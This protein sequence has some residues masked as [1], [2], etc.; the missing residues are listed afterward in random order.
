MIFFYFLIFFI[1]SKVLLHS[2]DDDYLF[3][4]VSLGVSILLDTTSNLYVTYSLNL[5]TSFV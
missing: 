2:Q 4:N 5:C 3:A 1:N